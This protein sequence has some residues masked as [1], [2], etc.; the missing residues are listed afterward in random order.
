MVNILYNYNWGSI[1]IKKND[2]PQDKKDRRPYT[3]HVGIIINPA[4]AAKKIPP[5]NM[6]QSAH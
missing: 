4:R 6:Q 1:I 3:R 5:L 2:V